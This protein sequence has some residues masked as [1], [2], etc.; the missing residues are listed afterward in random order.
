MSTYCEYC[1]THPED[2]YNHTYHNSQ[3]GFPLEEDNL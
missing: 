3:Y 2:F 1:N